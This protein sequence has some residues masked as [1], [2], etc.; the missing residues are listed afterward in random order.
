MQHVLFKFVTNFLS[1]SNA[2]KDFDPFEEQKQKSLEDSHQAVEAL[3][4]R[5]LAVCNTLSSQT[6]NQ[7]KQHVLK[8]LEVSVLCDVK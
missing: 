2:L 4:E 8:F 3:T 5:I 6:Q 7:L 1:F